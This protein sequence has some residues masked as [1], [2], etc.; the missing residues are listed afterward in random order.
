MKKTFYISSAL[1]VLVILPACQNNVKL[2][3][4]VSYEVYAKC[5]ATYGKSA[6]SMQGVGKLKADSLS[7]IYFD[8]AIQLSSKEAAAEKMAE[9]T[10]Y[11][12]KLLQSGEKPYLDALLADIKECNAYVAQ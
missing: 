5:A 7:A 12:G 11:Y 3:D 1:L 2:S 9:R 4:K 8:K 6:G 10:N